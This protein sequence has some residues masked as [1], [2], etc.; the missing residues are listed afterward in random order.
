VLR[1]RHDVDRAIL[2]A[3]P[4]ADKDKGEDKDVKDELNKDRSGSLLGFDAVVETDKEPHENYKEYDKIPEVENHLRNGVGEIFS[5][6]HYAECIGSGTLTGETEKRNVNNVCEKTYSIDDDEK[7]LEDKLVPLLIKE[8]EWIKVQDDEGQVA[9]DG[10]NKVEAKAGNEG[11]QNA[12]CS[13][14][15]EISKIEKEKEQPAD[16]IKT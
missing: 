1:G 15:T 9:Y 3:A 12:A 14:S 7:K 6:S 13:Y 4:K 8:R 5:E 2:H 10:S 16:G 11:E